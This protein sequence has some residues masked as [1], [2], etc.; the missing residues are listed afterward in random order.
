MAQAKSK[1]NHILYLVLLATIAAAIWV[2][3]NEE[4]VDD[5]VENTVV[6]PVKAASR[7]KTAAL[8]KRS[9]EISEEKKLTIKQLESNLEI[10]WQQLERTRDLVSVQDIFKPHSWVTIVPPPPPP[11]EP[12]PPPPQAPPVPFVY[13]GKM[14]DAQNSGKI[15]LTQNNKFYYVAKGEN[16]NSEWRF[17]KE[18]ANVIR[19]TYLP[20]NLPK[21]LSK[22]AR[23]PVAQPTSVD[24]AFEPN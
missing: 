7:S 21:I 6:Q 15:F 23:G 12:P 5:S 1:P 2:T 20:L 24:T 16:I 14:V 10:P 8:T 9:I 22:T 4:S 13:M 11:P 19:L 3:L 17:D 18:E